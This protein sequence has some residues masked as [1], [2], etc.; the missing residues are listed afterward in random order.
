MQNAQAQIDIEYQKQQKENKD[1]MLQSL[2]PCFYQY[3]LSPYTSSYDS[4][5]D[6]KE[7]V[8]G[9]NDRYFINKTDSGV[10]KID[11]KIGV[12]QCSI[13]LEPVC[14]LGKESDRTSYYE[15]TTRKCALEGDEIVLYIRMGTNGTIAREAIAYKNRKWNKQKEMERYKFHMKFL[16][17]FK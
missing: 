12:D 1:R 16:S 8:W 10:Y 6:W 2:S 15:R 5:T 11:G 7:D 13:P 4:S 9:L 3:A 14:Y 17:D